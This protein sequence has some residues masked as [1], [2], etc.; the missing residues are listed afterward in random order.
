[1]ADATPTPTSAPL[2]FGR[3][4]VHELL[5]ETR[6]S[7]VYAATDERLHRHVLMHLLRKE[8]A[9]QE[10]PRA[11]FI[12]EIGQSARRS[13]QALLEVFDSG[14]AAG[15]PFMITEYV[16]GR[17]LRGLGVLTVEQ[18]L[19]YMRQV[20]GAIAACQAGGDT[21]TP[22]GLYHPPISSSNVL[23]VDEGRVKLV[24]SW[25]L[26]T[27]AALADLAH[28]RAPELS[29][30]QP[31]TPASAVYSLGLLLYELITG[32]RPVS[33]ED[34]RATALAHLSARIPPLAQARPTLY[35]PAAEDLVAR[36]TARYPEHRYASAGEFATA[37]DGLWRNLGVSTQRLVAPSAR[38]ATPP[39]PALRASRPQG[40]PQPAAPAPPARPQPRS[41]AGFS[42]TE[43][44]RR[45]PAASVA[46]DVIRQRSLT[47]SMVGWA[48]MLGLLLLVAAGSYVGVNALISQFSQGS[49][50]NLPSLPGLPSADTSDGP[51]TWLGGLFG[52]DEVYIVN[53]AEGLNLRSQPD[54]NDPA[55]ILTVVAN[56]TP[57]TKLDGPV[58]KDN[59]PWLRV[60]VDTGGSH[61]EGWMS[62]NYLRQEP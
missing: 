30:G 33:G 10:R 22:N 7:S 59:I 15:R 58:V 8:L 57:V 4:R 62:L 23:L 28:Y 34:A 12:G 1:M 31:A 21:A 56:G 36:A 18:A 61:Y 5:G 2:L 49:A 40:D 39:A 26:P 25:Q 47:R 11:R 60:S 52:R 37:L 46:P 3:Y 29:E 38:A 13:H 43:R 32:Q 45:Q 55:T 20:A 35:L 53:L 9:G 48:V 19:L 50:P 24:D 51:L 27:D 6:L 14:E 41:P 44:L 17:P 54:V 16:S 42:V